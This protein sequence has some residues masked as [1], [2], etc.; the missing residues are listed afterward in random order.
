[1][2]NE[3]VAI[4]D[5]SLFDSCI[6][7]RSIMAQSDEHLK[8][9]KFIQKDKLTQAKESGDF[10]SAPLAFIIVP[11]K[12]EE[13][14]KNALEEAKRIKEEF[15]ISVC[16]LVFCAPKETRFADK[17]KEVKDIDVGLFDLVTT[18]HISHESYS[19]EEEVPLKVLALISGLVGSCESEK[20]IGFG[21]TYMLV[22]MHINYEN[23]GCSIR[24]LF[25]NLH[26]ETEQIKS[27]IKELNDEIKI[28]SEK[29]SRKYECLF[30]PH[31]YTSDKQKDDSVPR[32][33]KDMLVFCKAYATKLS[34]A[35]EEFAKNSQYDITKA[36]NVLSS[37]CERLCV[38]D[39]VDSDNLMTSDF[40]EDEIPYTSKDLICRACNADAPRIH[41]ITGLIP[42]LKSMLNSDRLNAKTVI[43]LML[44]LFVAGL[45]AVGCYIIPV[46]VTSG[47]ASFTN[48]FIGMLAVF[49]ALILLSSGIALIIDLLSKA[50][51]KNLIKNLVKENSDFLKNA[52]MRDSSIRAYI[53]KFI[54]VSINSFVKTKKI[55]VA[56][57]KINDLKKRI[58]MILDYGTKLQQKTEA[59]TSLQEVDI[60]DTMEDPKELEMYIRQHSETENEKDGEAPEI[61]NCQWIKAI[62]FDGNFIGS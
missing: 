8:T 51:L 4:I 27:K 42:L 22:T 1:M 33:I 56:Q 16:E 6:D 32:S 37:A 58:K 43:K 41:K 38:K 14:Y 49:I 31:T 12:S 28:L 53:N 30:S 47:T 57:A 50:R 45:I 59:L 7:F 11:V 25:E 10:I 46:A 52:S 54:T 34:N 15:E 9:I 48:T 23:L 44:I 26:D 19:P 36:Q 35:T 13:D 39:D 20:E 29:K 55:D 62:Y 3:V 61:K 17:I 5:S 21:H 24:M 2:E 40:G 60:A 18:L